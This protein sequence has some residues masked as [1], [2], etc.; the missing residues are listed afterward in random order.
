MP[1]VRQLFLCTGGH[2]GEGL[3]D[4]VERYDPQRDTWTVVTHLSSPCCLGSLVTLGD[5]LY[6]VGGYDGA[7]VLQ[8]LQVL[9]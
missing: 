5:K 6:A 3:L 9:S 8:T 1:Y 4:T 2:D 7:N